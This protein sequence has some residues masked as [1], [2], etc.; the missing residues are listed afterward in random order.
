M[1][2][3]NANPVGPLLQPLLIKAHRTN[4]ARECGQQHFER[5]DLIE[6]GFL[7]F[8]KVARIG[9]GQTFERGKQA[10]EVAY[11]TAGLASGEFGDVWILLLRHDRR[12][13]G[14]GIVKL[15]ETELLGIPDDDLL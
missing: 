10:S 5:V 4:H 8:L 12:A 3:A 9:C 13:S 14:I 6:H 11:E 1:S 2:V 15:H 7:V